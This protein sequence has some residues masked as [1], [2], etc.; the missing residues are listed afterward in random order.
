MDR[1]Q[2]SWGTSLLMV[3]VRSHEVNKILYNDV[4]GGAIAVSHCW[5]YRRL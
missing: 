1:G 3:K 4:K 2:R 5:A